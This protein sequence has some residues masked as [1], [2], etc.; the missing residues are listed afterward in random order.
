MLFKLA[1]F[2]E[3]IQRDLIILYIQNEKEFATHGTEIINTTTSSQRG[4]AQKKVFRAGVQKNGARNRV[5]I[6]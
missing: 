3:I 4:C 6:H 2:Q 5:R 1:R